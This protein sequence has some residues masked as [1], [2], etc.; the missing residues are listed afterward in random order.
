MEI[1]RTGRVK[2]TGSMSTI[3]HSKQGRNKELIKPDKELE[4]FFDRRKA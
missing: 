3:E 1:P 2:P 4:N